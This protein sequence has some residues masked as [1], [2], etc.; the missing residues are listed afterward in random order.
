MW[1][2][3]QVAHEELNT[4][5][6]M[7]NAELETLH[8]QCDDQRTLNERLEN[9]LLKINQ[10]TEANAG[11]K[12]AGTDPLAGLNLGKRVSSARAREG[13]MGLKTWVRC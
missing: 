6:S 5:H 9:D 1:I 4:T 11:T 12:N 7:L 13:K 8:A 2:D 10:A 3:P